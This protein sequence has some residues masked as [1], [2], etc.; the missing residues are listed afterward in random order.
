MKVCGEKE[1]KTTI[2]EDYFDQAWINENIL[3]QYVALYL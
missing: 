3:L 1:T 2:S